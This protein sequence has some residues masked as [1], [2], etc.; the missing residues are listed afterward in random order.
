MSQPLQPRRSARQI[1]PR[2]LLADEQAWVRQQQQEAREIQRAI[3]EAAATVEPSDSSESD[4][5]D[6]EG[7][8]SEDEQKAHPGNE[9]IAPWTRQLH[10][11]HPPACTALPVAT[12]PEHRVRTELGFLQCYID[13]ALIDHFVTNTNLYAA[14]RQA[15]AWVNTNT[16]EMWRYL[17][18]RIR[19]GIVE[20]P[21]LHMYWQ[22]GYRDKYVTQLM[23]RDRFMT[24]HRHFHIEPPVDRDVRQTVVEKTD[25]FYHQCQALFKQ[26]YQP[27]RDFALDETMIRFQGR[28]KWITVIKGKPTPVGFKLY[29]VASDDYLLDFRIF[30][31]KGGYANPQSVLHHVV[32]ELVK[33]WEGANRWLFFDNLYTS[34]TLCNHL[35][36]VGIRSCG[37]CRPNRKG[38]PADLKRVRKRLPKGETSTWQSGQLGCLVWNDAKPVIFLSTLRRVDQLTPIPATRGLPATTR[39]TVAVDYNFNKGHV[40]QVDQLRAYYVVQRRT[41]RTWPAVAWWLLDMCIS[42]AYKLWCLET[43]TKHGLLDF[44]EQLLQQIAAAYPSPHTHVQP[45]VPAAVHRGFVGHWPE[46]VD[47]MRNCRYCSKGR[48]RR[49][50]TLYRCMVCGVHLHAAPCFGAYHDRLEIDNRTV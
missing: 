27:G 47:A 25:T 38:L 14:A 9:N 39:P 13:P 29:T 11:V 31:G 44:R 21:E 42:N 16:D 7:S 43:N 22:H 3:A 48:K 19:Q 49:S 50:K 5:A 35:L 36:R 46:K 6:G 41:R 4:L 18:V 1:E 32:V 33:P 34:P 26:Y 10:D 2:R 17:A 8:D 28:S 24:L 40:D 23:T 15:A 30:R 45:H 20:L 12:L 37:T